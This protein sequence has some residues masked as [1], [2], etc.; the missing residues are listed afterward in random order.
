MAF[1]ELDA[2]PEMLWGRQSKFWRDRNVLRVRFINGTKRQQER[3]FAEMRKIDELCG[4]NFRRVM[5]GPAECRVLFNQNGHWSYV[6]IDN[7]NIPSQYQTMNLALLDRDSDIEYQRVVQHETLHLLGF[8]HEH[9]HPRS[10]IPWNKPAVY[11]FYGSTQGWSRQEIDQQVLNRE[12]TRMS[13]F[14]GSPQDKDSI[15]MY[16]IPKEL[17]LDPNYAV[18]WNSKLSEL[19]KQY[20]LKAYPQ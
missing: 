4:M 9:Q 8:H 14:F 12:T 18:G 16:P 11:R 13:D 2:H 10:T 17:V 15:M 6:G 19:D 7:L 5:S 20:L 1:P 3:T